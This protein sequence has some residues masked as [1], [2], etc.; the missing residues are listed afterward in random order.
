MYID[1]H[2]NDDIILMYIDVH[3]N[4]DIILM[5]IDVHQSDVTASDGQKPGRKGHRGVRTFDLR[6]L[7]TAPYHCAVP[8]DAI[9]TLFK[10]ADPSTRDNTRNMTVEWSRDAPSMYI[11]GPR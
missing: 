1:A 10:I 6:H 7:N 9:L 4:D 8:T 2:Q 5:Y 3:Q 11:D